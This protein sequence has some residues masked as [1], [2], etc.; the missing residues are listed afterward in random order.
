VNTGFMNLGK[1]CLWAGA[2]MATRLKVWK[3]RC[4]WIDRDT[5][6]EF[7]YSSEGYNSQALLPWREQEV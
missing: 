4:Q 5:G 2:V 1:D 7:Y 6:R 3:D